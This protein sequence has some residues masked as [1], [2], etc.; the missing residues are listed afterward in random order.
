MTWVL[1]PGLD[2]T[3]RLFA[4]FLERLG[5]E[6]PVQ[7]VSYPA[8]DVLNYDALVDRV[9]M[10]LPEQ[11]VLIAESFSGPI[12]IRLADRAQALVLV[13]SFAVSPFPLS[14][15][16]NGLGAWATRREPPEKFL[17]WLLMDPECSPALMRELQGAMREVSPEVL[18]SRIASVLDVDVRGQLRI[19]STPVLYLRAKRDRLIR[20]WSAVGDQ[21]RVIDGPH[22]LLQRR[23]DFVRRAIEEWLSTVARRG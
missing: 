4:P 10:E 22:L 6:Q 14:W 13:A 12:G 7:V 2:G 19:T 5:G 23:P 18:R 21:V 17:R 16:W 1:L 20:R 11:C 8:D 9:A 15:A 3:G